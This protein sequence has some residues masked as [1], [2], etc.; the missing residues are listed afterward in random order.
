MCQM[1]KAGNC[2]RSVGFRVLLSVALLCGLASP[3]LAQGISGQVNDATGGVLPG[4]TVEAASPVLIEQVR[5][6]L[7]DGDGRYSIVDLRP[8]TY[9]VNFSLPGFGGIIREGIE[10]ESGFT[11][12]V[13]AQLSVGAL[14][15]SITITGASPVVDVQNVTTR[16]VITSEQLDTLPVSK[17]LESLVALVPGLSVSAANRDT[18]GSSGDRPSATTIHGSRGSDQHIF[19]DGTR[20]NNINSSAG[21]TGGGGGFSIYFNPASIAEIDLE[22]GQ[23]SIMSESGGVTINVIPRDGGNTFS[24]MILANG[25]NE[26]FQGTNLSD[27]L[28]AQ[29]LTTVPRIKGIFDLNAGIGGPI[30]QNKLWFHAAYR[31]WG[32][33]SF[34][35]GRF[36]TESSSDPFSFSAPVPDRSRQAYDQNLARDST[37][38]FT[39]QASQNNKLSFV[40]TQQR[41]CLCYSGIKGNTVPQASTRTLDRSHRW[42]AKWTNTM[43]NRLLLQAGVSGNK[44]NWHTGLQPGVGFDIISVRELSTGLR[45]RAPAQIAG[46]TQDLGYNSSTYHVNFSATYVTGSHSFFVGTNVMHA[47]PTTDWDVNGDMT[48]DFFNGVPNRVEMRA[49]PQSLKNRVNDIGIYA[50]DQWT[51]DRMTVNAGIRYTSF[52]GSIPEQVLAAG[53]FVPARNFAPVPDVVDWHDITPRAGVAYDLF[54]DAKTALKFSVSKFLI[55]HAGDVVNSDNPQTRVADRAGRSWTDANG[56][57]VPDCDLLA[58]GA[59]GECGPISDV[60]FGQVRGISTF[61]DRATREGWGSR[62]NNWEITTGIQH[63]LAPGVSVEASYFRRWFGNFVVTD[64]RTVNNADFD[65]FCVTAPLDSRLPGGGGNEICGLYDINPSAF[66]QVDN[67]ITFADNFGSRTEVYNGVDLLLNARLPGGALI[68]GGANIGRTATNDCGVRIDSPQDRFCDV[69]PKFL[70]DFKLSLS[71]PTVWD[72]QVAVAIQSTPGP[73][74]LATQTYPS[75]EVAASLGRPLASGTGG[76]VSVDL[77][78]PGTLYA[79]RLNELDLRISKTVRLEQGFSIRAG[80]DVYNL[81]NAAPPLTVNNSFGPAWQRPL[82]I[83][84]GRFVKFALQMDF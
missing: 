3:A 47:R 57:F 46:P 23:Q 37:V 67:F 13:D 29:G 6:V 31:R 10:L 80:L 72:I 64:N 60:N 26:D 43:T 68:N 32:A 25:T 76:R 17:S 16:E 14:E 21:S 52:K 36:F 70:T 33:E 38:R 11:A 4:V 78:E 55:G 2:R 63:E 71:Y 56:D 45:Y 44:M 58:P 75:A 65:P 59:N 5:V 15:E 62:D 20:T 28:I 42:A 48:F 40:F 66:G 35:P 34:V 12:T 19:Y 7:T 39:N 24:G 77:V 9:T 83:L 61:R 81:T 27:T 79:D 8:G 18:G 1:P 84:P 54:G 69:N 73:Q 41:R 51:V 22:V 49:M 53:T 82:L 30:V 74:I 50:S